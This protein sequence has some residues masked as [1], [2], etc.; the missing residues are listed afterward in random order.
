MYRTIVRGALAL[1]VAATGLL[2]VTGGASASP[3]ALPTLSLSR[4]L[5]IASPDGATMT[6]RATLSAASTATVAVQYATKNG[7]A[8]AGTD[9]A[10]TS[11]T[12]VLAAGST[13]G[14][15][16][17]P[18][19]PVELGAGGSNKA[20]SLDLSHATGATLATPSVTGI[21]H[22]DVFDTG[23]PD[24]FADVVINPASTVAYFTV[25]LLNEVAVLHLATG[26]YGKPI[27]VGSNPHGIDITPDG[28][29][30]YVCDTGGQ[31]I[32]KV[33]IAAR[34]VTTITTPSSFTNDTPYT[35]AVMNNGHA[36][37]TTTFAG[38]GFGGHAY[39][40]NLSTNVST[41]VSN[42]GIG[43]QTTEFSPV[44]R[45]ADYSTVGLVLG[46]DSGGTFEVYLAATGNSVSGDLNAFISSSSLDG[47]G[48]TMLVD[49]RY[50]IDAPAAALL[51]TISDSGGSS[52]LNASGS[53]GYVL[54]TQSIVKLI[55]K[56]FLTGKKISLPQPANGGAQLALSPSGSILVAETVGGATIVEI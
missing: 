11:G 5:A 38:S 54:E 46:D 20:F 25:P 14:T 13:S 49:G 24:A 45:S 35:I 15:V 23:S 21:I 33:N 40:L 48:S 36:I 39:D 10:A 30:L 43:G 1:A 12:L 55:I 3:A 17:V 28:K 6:F 42:L 18:L 37:Y 27:P 9:Y 44:S 2:T 56:R 16:S 19:L 34:K 31:T 47:D 7:T 26:T 22:P 4:G 51:G 50:V 32:S 29:T 8:L 41:V 52:V 53:T